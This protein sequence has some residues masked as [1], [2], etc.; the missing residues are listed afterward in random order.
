MVKLTKF[1]DDFTVWVMK[2]A[3]WN[4]LV[5]M[6]FICE[7]VFLRYV[8]RM[9]TIWG[10][11]VLTMISAIGR[12]VGIGYAQ[13]LRSHIIMDIFTAKLDFKKSKMLDLFN[14]VFFFFP[15]VIALVIATFI[16]ALKSWRYHET[17]YTVWRPP[18]YPVTFML[19]ACYCL[20]ALQGIS[21]VVKDVIS[22]R[23][24]SDEW[25]KGR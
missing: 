22:L 7:E 8:L 16:R 20:M 17:M 2:W 23:K 3:K 18:L 15:L 12:M 5:I 19:V 6:V 1:I 13:L 11:D 14:Y 21:E 10:S 25:I 4:A 9:P 24:G